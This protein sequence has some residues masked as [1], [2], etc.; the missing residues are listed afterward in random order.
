MYIYFKRRTAYEKSI[1]D[2]KSEVLWRICWETHWEP[3]G[4]LKGTHWEPGK[5]GPKKSFFHPP[6]LKK[7]GGKKTRYL[8]WAFPIGYMK[9]SLAQRVRHHFW[10]GL[11]LLAKNTLPI[12]FSSP[13]VSSF[14]FEYFC[15]KISF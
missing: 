1:W 13:R 12:H 6:K 8:E 3:I 7:G 2:K 10:P 15:F 11:I 14:F 4:N 5:I 9:F